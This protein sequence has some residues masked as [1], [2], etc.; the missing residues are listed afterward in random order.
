MTTRKTLPAR[1]ITYTNAYSGW[2]GEMSGPVIAFLTRLRRIPMGAWSR[3]A[4]ADP[5]TL[6]D[7]AVPAATNPALQ[8]LRDEEADRM[9]RA[10]LSEVM[11]TMPDV[12]RRIRRRIDSDLTVLDGIA[13]ST[14]VTRMRRAARLAACAIAARPALSAAEFERLYR[15]FLELIPP[16]DLAL[17]S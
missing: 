5:L 15:P 3:T 16:Q 2:Y 10:R 13:A 8:L 12:V 4:E 14:A 1:S 6:A 9:A 17:R 7:D 11:E